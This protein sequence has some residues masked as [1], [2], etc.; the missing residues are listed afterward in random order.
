MSRRH[1]SGLHSIDIT[2]ASE[3]QYDA[4]VVG[5]GVSGSIIA[6]EL[7]KQN[8]KVLVVEAGLGGDMSISGY[9]D[10]LNTFYSATDKSPNSPYRKNKNA[11]MPRGADVHTLK[12]KPDASSYIV[13]NGPTVLDGTYAR[14]VGGTTMH[15]Q[16]N[17]PRML[18]EDF[19]MQTRF[20]KGIDWPISYEDL[21]PY[22]EKAE[23][24]MGVSADVEEQ[25]YSGMTF[26]DEYVFPMHKM[27][28]T[29]LDLKVANRIDGMQIE[30][31]GDTHTLQV[32]GI[33]QARNGIPNKAYN[34]GQGYSPDGSVSSHQSE[35][36]GRCQGN[37]N[38]TPICP[39]QAKYDARRTLAKAMRTGRVDLLKQ[40]IASK[41]VVD[42]ETGKV[43]EIEV[44]NYAD[45]TVTEYQ[46]AKIKGRVFVLA[47][48]AIENA[49]LML[50]S[51][52]KSSS[53]LMGCHLMN[54]VY[55]FS[56]A[57][58][59][60]RIGAMRGTQGTS[61]IEDLRG[62]SFRNQHAGFHVDIVNNGWTYATGAPATDLNELV[63]NGNK[64]GKAL[65]EALVDTVSRQVLLACLI[66]IMPNPKNRVKVDPEYVDAVGNLRPVID[67]EVDDYSLDAA[68]FGRSVARRLFQRLGAEDHTSYSPFDFGYRE[69][70]GEAVTIYG[71]NHFSGTHIMGSSPEHS[72]VNSA[73]RSW[74]HE[75][76]Y[77]AS[78]GSMPT[79]GTSNPTLTLAA[80]CYMTV[81]SI[82]EELG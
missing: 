58:M 72:V 75:N 82:V 9:E 52:L 25:A 67:Y 38:C 5:S 63:D 47:A 50:A 21:I 42:P 17:T 12:E 24:E 3:T 1:G 33:P 6:Y 18:P 30:A 43:I 73:Q 2:T 8:Y 23:Y 16:G 26:Q 59:P 78:S 60:E 55:L 31:G 20:G 61:G 39:V 28:P 56:W 35:T 51:D 69:Q 48:N 76:L 19:E 13:Q 14:V 70:K 10:Y 4:V 68:V 62:G 29:Y 34:K 66:D 15:W 45:P 54:H 74:D 79:I 77:L 37:T 71:G 44:K 57:L 22:Y 80:L 64:Y 11:P 41:V 65:K 49:R 36:G 81:E 27:P 40:T 7:S 46:T 32:R 53:G